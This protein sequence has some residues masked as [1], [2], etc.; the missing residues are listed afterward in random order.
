MSSGNPPV[1]VEVFAYAS[2]RSTLR[3]GPDAIALTE[4]MI[5]FAIRAGVVSS[6]AAGSFNSVATRA[7]YVFANESQADTAST[8]H[9]TNWAYAIWHKLRRLYRHL[10]ECEALR[11]SVS[12]TRS[13]ESFR[14][15]GMSA[16][17]NA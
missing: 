3:S 8:D 7:A 12:Y 14:V 5:V 15:K 17:A 16:A 6:P 13:A 11:G 9:R 4:A 10:T 1:P 2:L